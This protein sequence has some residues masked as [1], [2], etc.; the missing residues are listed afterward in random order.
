MPDRPNVQKAKIVN[1]NN[2]QSIV[3]HFNPDTF[4]LD[5]TINWNAASKTGGDYPDLAFSGGQAGDLTMTLLFDTTNTGDDVRNAYAALVTMSKVDQSKKDAKTDKGEPPRC[6]F[7]W[8]KF[9]TFEAVITKLGEKF[10][11]FKADGTPLRAEVTVTFKQVAEATRGQNPT[12]RTESRKIWVVHEGQTLDWI[13]YQ[14]Y[15]DSSYWRHIAETN[16]LA[17]PLALTPGQVLKLVPLP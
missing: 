9:L 14:E 6:R 4:S 10:L 8:G 16:N 15:G 7:E 13:A 2:Q 17:D 1:L 3:C 12:T 11:M 5:R